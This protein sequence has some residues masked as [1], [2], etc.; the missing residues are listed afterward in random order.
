MDHT[1]FVCALQAK[2][3]HLYKSTNEKQLR[4]SAGIWCHK[5]CTL[6]HFT[7]QYIHITT[8]LQF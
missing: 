7:P 5:M 1:K 4:A 6:Y 8:L 2:L 3:V